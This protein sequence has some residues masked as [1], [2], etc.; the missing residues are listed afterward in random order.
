M[1]KRHAQST[2]SNPE[3][4]IEVQ[5]DLRLE[6]SEANE[7]VVD[8]D[9]ADLMPMEANVFHIVSGGGAN[10]LVPRQAQVRVT[11][12]GGDGRI[13]G[14]ESEVE[15]KQVGGDLVL[16]NLL[17]TTIGQVGG[18]VSAKK[19]G[20]SLSVEFA[21]GDVSVRGVAGPFKAAE[22]GGD[23]AVRDL[24][25][26][27]SGRAKGDVITNMD[28]HP[29]QD[30]TFEAF[31]DAICRVPRG[32]SVTFQIDSK[33]EVSW[34][35]SGARVEG[36]DGGMHVI[37]GAGEAV[38]KLSANGD[39]TLSDITT[40]SSGV[41]ESG[42]DFGDLASTIEARVAEHIAE[43]EKE[44]NERFSHLNIDL[45]GLTGIDAERIAQRA[46]RAAEAAQRKQEETQRK[47]QAK[48]EAAQR[49]AEAYQRKAE[50]MAERGGRRRSWGF[51]FTIPT[52]PTPPRPP[53]GFAAIR[54]QPPAGDP[55]SDEERMAILRLVEQ[56]KIT[57]SEAEKLLAALE[58]K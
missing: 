44:I 13:K 37:V 15:V 55:V 11:G 25:A 46:R 1:T 42:D 16:R 18:D 58:G 31:G 26:S 39:V 22:V 5:G 33:G 19:I 29:G 2:N 43:V 12:C 32:A 17:S 53:M 36:E 51:N 54:T 45:S 50:R 3:V 52:P 38:V 34:D 56:G 10:V 30:Y 6:G 23:L 14:L 24:N 47:V 21:G 8:G 41:A 9:E 57:A 4:L 49:K 7:I 35:I 28:F 20:G 27:A 40:D 48:V